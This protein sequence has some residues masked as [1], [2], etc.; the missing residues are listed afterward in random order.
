MRRVAKRAWIMMVFVTVL[1][2][3]MLFFLYE[4]AAKSGDWVISAGSPHVYSGSNMNCGVITDREGLLLLDTREGRIYSKDR[5]IRRGTLHWVGDRSGNIHAAA[6]THYAKEMAGFDLLNGVY[7]YG[8]AGGQTKLTL[9]AQVQKAALAALGDRKGVVAV[10]NYKT[11]EIL[12]AVSTPT[13]DPD[14]VPD[15]SGDTTGRY[16]G[17]YL[18]RF[19]QSTYIP[20]STFKIVTTAV[21]LETV[22]DI[23]EM[24]FTCSGIR[25]YGIDRVTCERAHGAQDLKTALA[26]S[27]NCAFAEIS[28]LVGR[29]SMMEY[30]DRFGLTESVSFDG[31]TTAAG[32]YDVSVAAPVELA[33]SC[34]GQY[35]DQMNPCT[36]LAFLGAVVHPKLKYC[37]FA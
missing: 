18:N 8:G 27:C 3:G 14:N 26:N 32:N 17:V 35:T 12:C 29:D 16:D 23:E 36:F 22:A 10:Y 30:V 24:T 4:Y 11:G 6:V 20:G 15:I 1:L 21:A 7:S 5:D 13:F 31:I 28:A 9:S 19:T 37:T 33:W 34:I 2:G 25:E